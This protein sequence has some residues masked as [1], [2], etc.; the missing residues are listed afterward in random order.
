TD[1]GTTGAVTPDFPAGHGNLA[2]SHGVCAPLTLLSSALHGGIVVDGHHQ[3]IQR[4]LAWLA[5]WRQHDALG[6][7]WPGFI[8]PDHVRSRTVPPTT[9]QKLS[10]CYGTPGMARA[11]QLAGLAMGDRERQRLA[12]TAM[13][14]ALSDDH[15]VDRIRDVG[16]CHG[17]AGVLQTTWRMA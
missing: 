9:Q 6:P 7:W 10:W 13:L 12:E 8:T 1:V 16:L 3:A 14:A 15:Q 4:I 11:Q 5:T 17:I 2:L